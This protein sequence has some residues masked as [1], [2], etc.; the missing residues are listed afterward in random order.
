MAQADYEWFVCAFQSK[1]YTCF[2]KRFLAFFKK[3]KNIVVIATGFSVIGWQ[4][5]SFS[6][7]QQNKKIG[8]L[9]DELQEV[10]NFLPPVF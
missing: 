8:D 6:V 10:E 3:E 4:R 2:L 7:I 1:Q 5:T 9:C